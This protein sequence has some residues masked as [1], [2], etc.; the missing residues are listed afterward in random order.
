MDGITSQEARQF[1]EDAYIYG[2]PLVLMEMTRRVM[3]NVSAPDP[4]SQ[5]APLGQ[6][7]HVN[8]L[9]T[10]HYRQVSFPNIDTLYSLAWL[11]LSVGPMVLHVPDTHG[12]Y[13]LMSI[14]DAWSDIIA[15]LG[16]RTTGTRAADFAIVSPGWTAPLPAALKVIVAPTNLVWIIVRTRVNG[17]TDAP[18]VDAI[19]QGYQLKPLSAWGRHYTP[20][21]ALVDPA[22][23]GVTPPKDQVAHMDAATFFRT[24]AT[25]LHANPPHAVDGLMLAKLAG[26]GIIAGQR[27]D[28]AALDLVTQQALQHAVPMAQAQI[29]AE[30]GRIGEVVNGWVCGLGLGRYS[31]DY[32]RRAAVAC[33]RLGADLPADAFCLHT[34]M[35][36]AGAPLF[37]AYNYVLHFAPHRT[38]PV[39]SFWSLSMY[40]P[41]SFFVDNP[42]DRYAIGNRDALQFNPDGSLDI[43]IQHDVPDPEKQANWL[44]APAGN[45]TLI[46]RMYWPK[47]DVFNRTWT[48]PALQY[49]HSAPRV[50]EHLVF[51]PSATA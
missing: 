12:R 6:F 21:R 48:P 24:L 23:D 45:F 14:H 32:V 33:F 38:P 22:V 25:S 8:T 50:T 40:G 20:S 51:G 42:I 11:D 35:D 41:D 46:L 2:Y 16:K 3:T 31:T 1:A 34:E 5:K 18:T 10:A 15:V 17:R 39:N 49:V 43:Y 37:G 47:P 7:V 13:Y 44:P 29:Q 4:T 30:I 28:Y 36:G 9:P 26:L 27:F 19:Q